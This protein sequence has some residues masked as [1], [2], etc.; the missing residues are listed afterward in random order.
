MLGIAI[1][2]QPYDKP[3]VWLKGEVKTPPFSPA[4]R[5]AAGMLLRR[6]QRGKVLGLPH[7]R[8]MPS[9]GTWCHELRIPDRDQS[10]RIV[11]HIAHDAIAVLEVFSKKTRATPK[12]LVE[13]CRKRLAS[14]VKAAADRE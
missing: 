2:R 7:S 4:A 1:A 13:L 10:W 9:I 6:P 12:S 8:P 3:V 14:F 11:Y 5:L